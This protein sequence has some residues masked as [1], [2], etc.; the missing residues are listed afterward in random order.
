MCSLTPIYYMTGYAS[1]TSLTFT[2]F[3]L[4]IH[5]S[6]RSF[7]LWARTRFSSLRSRRLWKK[8]NFYWNVCF[9]AI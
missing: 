5:I 7:F 8:W 6:A 3:Y 1:W 2:M 9:D 4:F